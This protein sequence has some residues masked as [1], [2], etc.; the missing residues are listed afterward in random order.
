ML[1]KKPLQKRVIL[2]L[3]Q[4][5]PQTINEIA[6]GISRDWKTSSIAF[7]KLEKEGFVA[8]TGKS[9]H[10]RGRKFPYFWLTDLGVLLAICEGVKPEVLLKTTLEIYPENKDL[11]L[12]IETS[13]I[14]GKQALAV[15][16]LV[17]LNRGEIKQ[18]DLTSI[19]AAQM[20][21]KLT[22]KQ[23]KQFGK[24]LERYPERRQQTRK[25]LKELSDL[26]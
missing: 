13:P 17:V 15:L 2:Y 11:Q 12:I 20:L 3:A 19:F 4:T 14:L 7:K 16:Y 25:N 24:V 23:I 18:T 8:K 5:K 6:I 21:N 1:A 22:T 9:K 26:L 10:Y